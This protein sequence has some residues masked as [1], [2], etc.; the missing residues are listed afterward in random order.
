[1]LLSKNELNK[2]I[3]KTITNSGKLIMT[4]TDEILKK[5]RKLHPTEQA[6]LVDKLI[7]ILDEPDPEIDKLWA[8]EAESRLAAYKSGTLKGISLKD[9]LEKYQ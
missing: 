7:T 1:M 9:V 2:K 5:V 3:S 6:K 4:I 8:E